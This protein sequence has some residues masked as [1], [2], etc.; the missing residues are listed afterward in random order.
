MTIDDY[1]VL[2]IFVA[3]PVVNVIVMIAQN[4]QRCKIA[5][6]LR[7]FRKAA[8]SNNSGDSDIGDRVRHAAI[9]DTGRH[10]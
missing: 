2:A 6:L 8:N 10:R 3:A 9:V 5:K 1:I 7:T 4:R